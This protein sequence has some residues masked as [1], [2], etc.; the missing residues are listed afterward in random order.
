MNREDI[1]RIAQECNL[2]G[3][4]P[5]EDSMF[6]RD[7]VRFGERLLALQTN[8]AVL[9]KTYMAGY[10]TRESLEAMARKFQTPGDDER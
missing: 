5:P 4:Y 9:F 10:S 1:I 6:V 3:P 8:A 7:I 2:I